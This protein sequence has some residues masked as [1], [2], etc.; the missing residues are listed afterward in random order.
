MIMIESDEILKVQNALN[1]KNFKY[2]TV[3]GIS[4]E[5]K[6][7]SEEVQK[8]IDF[9]LEDIVRSKYRNQFGEQLFT[10]RKKLSQSSPFRRLG[11]ALANR[12]D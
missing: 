1:H 4:K 11:A 7:P 5:T 2:R 12:A 10:S 9:E 8:I 3:R 6:I